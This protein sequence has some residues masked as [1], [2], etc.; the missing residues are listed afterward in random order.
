MSKKH[1]VGIRVKLV[2]QEE[3]CFEISG[4]FNGNHI[5]IPVHV[6]EPFTC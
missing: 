3:V 2:K 4:Y 5:N 6:G 1:E